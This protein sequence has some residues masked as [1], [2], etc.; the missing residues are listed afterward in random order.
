MLRCCSSLTT[1]HSPSNLQA[2]PN[3]DKETSIELQ[4][5][6]APVSSGV[7]MHADSCMQ[8]ISCRFLSSDSTCSFLV[9]LCSSATPLTNCLTAWLEVLRGAPVRGALMTERWSFHLQA[10]AVVVLLGTLRVVES[11]GNQ[12][13]A[14]LLDNVVVKVLGKL[15]ASTHHDMFL[16]GQLGTK[17]FAF[18]CLEVGN[19][20]S[21]SGNT[22]ASTFCLFLGESTYWHAPTQ[23]ILMTVAQVGELISGISWIMLFLPVFNAFFLCHSTFLLIGIL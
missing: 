8:C 13:I 5:A 18:L 1:L 16:T 7:I 20:F 11:T 4:H 17:W 6:L 2:S 14:V 21:K 15:L 12:C 9:V 23:L 22:S 19:A 3:V 10:M